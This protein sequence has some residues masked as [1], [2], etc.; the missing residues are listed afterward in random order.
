VKLKDVPLHEGQHGVGGTI[1][2]SWGAFVKEKKIERTGTT[3]DCR[4]VKKEKIVNMRK[5]LGK[6]RLI[7]CEESS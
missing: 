5:T 6:G 7:F 4:T 1:L 3:E 2:T